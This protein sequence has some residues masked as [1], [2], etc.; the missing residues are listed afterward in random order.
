MKRKATGT[1][2]KKGQAPKSEGRP[3]MTEEEK[4]LSKLTRTQFK[5][6]LREFLQYTKDELDHVMKYEQTTCLE[7]MV[8]SS[9]RAA[10]K[11][12]DERKLNWF[13]EQLLIV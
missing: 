13:M 10:I 1:P 5:S 7:L 6:I 4:K 9:L 2:F 3:T 11:L 12:G 8:G